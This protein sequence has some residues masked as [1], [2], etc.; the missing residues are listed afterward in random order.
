MESQLVATDLEIGRLKEDEA[1]ATGQIGRYRERIENTPTREQA[2]TDLTRDYQNTREAYQ[3]LL[4]K[5]QDAQRSENLE[6]RQKGEQFRIIDPARVPEKPF[7]PDI[8][9]V[10]LIGLFLAGGAGL[11]TAFFREQ[12]DRSFH[13]PGD[14]EAA[15]GLR[16]LANIPRVKEEPAKAA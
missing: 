4:Q 11:G 14:L 1:R 12:M 7:K 15:L 2:I 8:P 9:K 13:D 16:V 5:S 10:L 3:S 6:R